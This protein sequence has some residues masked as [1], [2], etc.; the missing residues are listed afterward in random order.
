MQD[1]LG[2]CSICGNSFPPHDLI[3]GELIRK[4][5][6]KEIKQGCKSWNEKQFICIADLATMRSRYVH[7]LLMSEK[8]ELTSLEQTV[9]DNLRRQELLSI[10][11]ENKLENKWTLG[12][13]LKSYYPPMQRN[14]NHPLYEISRRAYKALGH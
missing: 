14:L 9:I 10:D 1:L 8:S 13:R 6:V 2:I 4:E 5:I 12:E 11:I 3:S 7:S